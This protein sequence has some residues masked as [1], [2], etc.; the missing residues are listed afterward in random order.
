MKKIIPFILILIPLVA[1]A[2]EGLILFDRAVQYDFEIPEALESI[3]DQ[4]PLETVTSMVLYFNETESLMEVVPVDEGEEATASNPR[5]AGM[6]ARLKMGSLQRND[7]ETLLGAYVNQ[8]DGT[9]TESM[10]FMGRTF[11]IRGD[12]PAYAWKLSEDQSEFLGYMVQKATAELDSSTVE[13]WFTPEI[14]VSAG[15]GLFGGLPGMILVVVSVDDGRLA[16]SATEVHLDGLEEG[17]IIA[18]D[19]GRK[20]SREEY[21][22][23]VEEKLEEIE[24]LKRSRDDRSRGDRRQ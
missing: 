15:P 2:Q 20:V 4:I 14:P 22:R 19:E 23:I 18:P 24:A 8:D 16:Y 10:D 1:P 17:A 13:A 7:H 11:I 5:A 9:I 21:E 12:Q 3:R 6:L